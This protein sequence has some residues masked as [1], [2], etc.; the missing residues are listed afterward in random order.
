[1]ATKL[2]IDEDVIHEARALAE[3]EH[4]AVD[5]IVSEWARVGMRRQ[6][7]PARRSRNGFTLLPITNPDAVITLE[8]VNALRDEEP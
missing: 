7:V 8:I 1:M 4:R 6:V 3:R 2:A 5:Q